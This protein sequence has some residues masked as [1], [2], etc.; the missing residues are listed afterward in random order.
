MDQTLFRMLTADE[1]TLVL[2][3]EAK[4][5]APL[6]EDALVELHDR[7]RRARTKYT[8]LYR[9][10]ASAQV[11]ADAARGKASAKNANTAAKAEIFEDALARVSRRL[12][13]VARATAAE[14]RAERLAAAGTARSRP[15]S[16]RAA[17]RRPAKAAGTT[18]APAKKTAAKRATSSATAGRRGDGALRSPASK[19]AQAQSRATTR[20][21]QAKRAAR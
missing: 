7:V 17:T 20:R 11:R 12:A 9:R 10:Q 2:A 13:T 4:R 15:V 14:L 18:R 3:T 19:R 16:E 6:D 8:K 5:L 1:Q 21:D